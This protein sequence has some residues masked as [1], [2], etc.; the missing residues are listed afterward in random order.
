[1]TPSIASTT[2]DG[3][4]F[5]AGL[6]GVP[7]RRGW[8]SPESDDAALTMEMRLAPIP[9]PGWRPGRRHSKARLAGRYRSKAA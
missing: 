9:R 6:L 8:P 1:M 5:A 7:G 4:G 2:R 3:I